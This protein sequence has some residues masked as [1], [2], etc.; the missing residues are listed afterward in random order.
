MQKR[1]TYVVTPP[2]SSVVRT[3]HSPAVQ[4][5]VGWFPLDAAAGEV[6]DARDD[7]VDFCV[8]KVDAVAFEGRVFEVVAAFCEGGVCVVSGGIESWEVIGGCLGECVDV[9]GFDD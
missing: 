7:G 2:N 1:R 3:T 9:H 8:T 4:G 6:F 5:F